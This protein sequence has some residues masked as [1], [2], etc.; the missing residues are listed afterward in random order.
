MRAVSA[1]QSGLK[2]YDLR[3]GTVNTDTVP[4][5][6]VGKKWDRPPHFFSDLSL[7]S[8]DQKKKRKEKKDASKEHVPD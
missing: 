2:E 4:I 1:I 6:P 3:L 8:S 5:F 7:S